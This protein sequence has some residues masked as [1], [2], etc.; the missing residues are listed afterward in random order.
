M[1]GVTH[2]STCL[3]RTSWR[4]CFEV[5]SRQPSGIS[6]LLLPQQESPSDTSSQTPVNKPIQDSITVAVQDLVSESS[7]DPPDT[8]SQIM[9]K[10]PQLSLRSPS[11]R[12]KLM[13]LETGMYSPLAKSP[14]PPQILF[15][16][17]PEHL[18]NWRSLAAAQYASIAA[19]L[20]PH[21]R[22]PPPGSWPALQIACTSEDE[23]I[24]SVHL[25]GF[26]PEMVTL[27]TRRE[28]RLS[29]V[30]DLWHA[31]SNCTC[32]PL[33]LYLHTPSCAFTHF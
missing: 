20:E 32:V 26:A 17:S 30:A 24:L 9:P 33:S 21:R 25:P 15:I 29:V 3:A 31:E 18:H 14:A 23:Y 16:A 19:L 6:G 13:P 1:V 8:A 28:D 2:R 11:S 4:L 27:S 22:T 10:A 12:P 7:T 5:C